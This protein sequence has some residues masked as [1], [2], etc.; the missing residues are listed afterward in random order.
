MNARRRSEGFGDHVHLGVRDG[1]LGHAPA[2]RGGHDRS[3][4][5][6]P[7][8]PPRA[9]TASFRRHRWRSR[10]MVVLAGAFLSLVACTSWAGTAS[11]VGAG[12]HGRE[13]VFFDDGTTQVLEWNAEV[14]LDLRIELQAQQAGTL[15][16]KVPKFVGTLRFWGKAVDDHPIL[17]GTFEF[18]RTAEIVNEVGDGT[19]RVA[20]S[21]QV[22][23]AVDLPLAS[24]PYLPRGTL[25]TFQRD[26]SGG[27]LELSAVFPSG[28]YFEGPFRFHG[29]ATVTPSCDGCKVDIR[30]DMNGDGAIDFDDPEDASSPDR[31]FRF[32]LNSDRDDKFRAALDG[33]LARNAYLGHRDRIKA[34]GVDR[35][36]STDMSFFE[37]D[38]LDGTIDHIRDLEDFAPVE[39][40][41][42]DAARSRL[43]SGL[44]YRL[45]LQVVDGER[46][47]VFPA[48]ESG[49]QYVFDR[50]KAESFRDFATSKKRLKFFP[51][52]D[53]NVLEAS[54]TGVGGTFIFEGT[55]EGRTRLRIALRDPDGVEVASQEV[56]LD[57]HELR[58]MYGSA[59][60]TFD[61]FV[62]G[63]GETFEEHLRPP[64]KFTSGYVAAD[65]Q[66]GFVR[67]EQPLAG[68]T[69]NP[70]ADLIVFVHGCCIDAAS[71]AT[72]SDTTFKRLWWQ[73][74]RGRFARFRWP[75]IPSFPNPPGRYDEEE[76]RAWIYGQ[77]FKSYVATMRRELPG[78]RIHVVAHSVGNVMVSEAIKRGAKIDHYVLSQAAVGAGI[79]DTRDE[80]LDP[81][82]TD[83]ALRPA[84]SYA[85]YFRRMK[86]KNPG[87]WMVNFFND[88]DGAL[89]GFFRIGS[90]KLEGWV[91]DQR[92]KPAGSS[93]FL[94]DTPASSQ[95]L[96]DGMDAHFTDGDSQYYLV[97]D[98]AEK[99]AFASRPKTKAV[100]AEGRTRGPVDCAVDIGKALLLDNLPTDHG[101]QFDKA[102]QDVHTY[103]ALLLQ[104]FGLP[105]NGNAACLSPAP[106]CAP[107]K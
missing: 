52:S 29:S 39:V 80:L 48:P 47:H 57:L 23:Q 95:Y 34:S 8:V 16:Y 40:R 100:G 9:S 20:A 58:S 76:F 38:N 33:R 46:I 49:R 43:N 65:H 7:T 101:A 107:V 55:S 5:G 50:A 103:Y 104:A 72:I 63:D 10:A 73:G 99:R 13:T 69:E 3:V 96:F 64:Y 18:D 12:Y 61:G 60:G 15:F 42:N 51:T 26:G 98:P 36:P 31:A 87:L 62:E 106:P 82:L 102:N 41:T 66:V 17:G 44:G 92:S 1:V 68:L 94:A 19:F 56:A 89:E 59:E 75:S 90:I 53:P 79:Y 24:A 11:I 6:I 54:P 83:G 91:T 32:W 93:F 27:V 85:G 81:R 74:Y 4:A 70:S 45:V 71:D 84:A 28:W 88:Q 78:H 77:A 35:Q 67:T 25:L 37:P 97:A 105:C 14:A 30:V 22:V 2:Q 86:K 21:S